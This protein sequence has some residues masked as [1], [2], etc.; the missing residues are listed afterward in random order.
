[1]LF[2][3]IALL[4]FGLFL[5]WRTLYFDYVWDDPLLFLDKTALLNESL[6][7]RLLSEPVLPGTSYLRPLVFLTFFAEFR[8]FGQSPII[9][10]GVNLVIFL[11][12]IS[13][14]FFVTRRISLLLGKTG[15]GV[16]FCTSLMYAAHPALVESVAWV[17][18]RFDLL[19]TT[20]ILLSVLVYLSDVAGWLRN[21][22]LVLIMLSGLFS[23]ELAFVIPIVLFCVWI[24][25]NSSGEEG[26]LQV[27][28][29]AMKANAKL[30]SLLGLT[31]FLYLYIRAGTVNGIYHVELN[32]DY[33]KSVWWE[34]LLPIQALKFYLSQIFVPFSNVNPLHPISDLEPWGI[35]SLIGSAVLLLFFAFWLTCA[36]RSRSASAWLGLA[37]LFCI[38]PV[39]HL[40]PLSIRDNIGHERFMTTALAFFCM[41]V[42]FIPYDKIFEAIKIAADRGRKITTLLLVGW[43]ALAVSTVHSILPFWSSDLQL[44]NWAYR[45]HPNIEVARYNYLYGALQ[46]NRLDLV[47]E[48]I[49]ELQKENGGLDVGDQL[50]YA[51]SLFRRGDQESMSYLQG[52]LYALPEFHLFAEGRNAADTFHLTAAQISGA[53]SL[54]SIGMLVFFGDAKSALKYNDIAAWYLLE[55][56]LIPIRYQ[57]AAI[58]YALG[59]AEQAERIVEE[60]KLLNYYRKNEVKIMLEQILTKYCGLDVAVKENCSEVQRHGLIGS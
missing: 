30:F 46:D 35:R 31:F 36:V 43:L 16:A 57:R 50:L 17:S 32:G 42:A 60:Q 40:I 21:A 48:A 6:S 7:W 28:V 33:I 49:G 44:W 41:A 56:E 19:V 23:K 26:A 37:G 27:F 55:S 20:F 3:L 39:I 10:H 25:C 29:R 18:G 5:Y 15:W 54:Y 45:A 22:L 1:M 34:G 12:N 24:A 52:V 8:I 59:D 58:L 38:L 11:V 53:Y 2:L 14:L 47:E 51:H 9:S 4:L 13:I